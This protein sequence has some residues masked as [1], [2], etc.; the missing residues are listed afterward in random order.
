M[1]AILNGNSMM[2]RPCKSSAEKTPEIFRSLLPIG[3]PEWYKKRL[4][5]SFSL[6]RVVTMKAAVIRIGKL[7]FGWL[8]VALGLL[9]LF[10]PI[11]PGI[12]FLALGAAL[13]SSESLWV[14]QKIDFV[15]ARYPRFALRL[16]RATE[17]LAPRRL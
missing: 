10:L 5:D 9:G 12:L 11:L 3:V 7:C 8:L 16:K 15:V 14:R 6:R 1:A 2:E 4:P 17:I 13:L